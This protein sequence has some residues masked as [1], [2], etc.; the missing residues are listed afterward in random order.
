M[1]VDYRF[2]VNYRWHLDKAYTPCWLQD[3]V[4]NGTFYLR[5]SWY[6]SLVLP[7]V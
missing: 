1:Q 5:V 2:R 4:A 6:Y 3:D 7:M